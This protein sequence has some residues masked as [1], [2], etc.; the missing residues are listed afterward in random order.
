[1]RRVIKYIKGKVARFLFGIGMICMGLS[2]KIDKEAMGNFMLKLM[3]ASMKGKQEKK[4]AG[5]KKERD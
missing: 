3:N 1:M 2:L 4:D 5:E